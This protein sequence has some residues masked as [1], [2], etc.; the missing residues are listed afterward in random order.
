MFLLCPTYFALMGADL[1]LV[2]WED[3]KRF[4]QQ[5][6]RDWPILRMYWRD[7]WTEYPEKIE[8]REVMNALRQ[9]RRTDFPA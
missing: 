5:S 4:W 2:I 7:A 3:I 6:R 9:R 8:L 1:A